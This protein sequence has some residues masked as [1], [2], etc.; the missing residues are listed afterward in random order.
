MN[1]LRL[2]PDD[3]KVEAFVTLPTSG[4]GTVDGQGFDVALAAVGQSGTG[5]EEYSC[6]EDCTTRGED[7]SCQ[8][9]C[10][11]LTHYAPTCTYCTA[12]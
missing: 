9:T 6:Y 3:L 1:K 11:S 4:R 12:I 7:L 10:E 8:A 2:N 5:V